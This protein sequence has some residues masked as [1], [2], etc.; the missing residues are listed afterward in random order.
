MEREYSWRQIVENA[1]TLPVDNMRFSEL[2]GF[3]SMSLRDL[4]Q[5][6]LLP[7]ISCQTALKWIDLSGI[8]DSDGSN[9]VS[10]SEFLIEREPTE[11]LVRD[12]TSIL[13]GLRRFL[14]PT[15]SVFS[16]AGMESQS[17]LQL[18][19]APGSLSLRDVQDPLA[20][21]LDDSSSSPLGPVY[22][23]EWKVSPTNF[24]FP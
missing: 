19:S 23:A 3:S 4:I 17:W 24:L 6:V 21:L 9:S 20:G 11:I 7:S 15:C 8:L 16:S 18:L 12:P 2:D 10:D 14:S 1:E 22:S 13:R 5:T